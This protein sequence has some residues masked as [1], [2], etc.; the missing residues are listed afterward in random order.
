MRPLMNVRKKDQEE[1]E[2]VLAR[3]EKG[4]LEPPPNPWDIG[5]DDYLRS[6]KTAHVLQQWSEEMGEDRLLDTYGVTPGEMRARLDNA[7]WLL[8]STHE[9]A[10]LLGHK[11][12]LN[13][14][15]KSRLRL[16]YGVREELLSLVRLK[17]VGRARARALFRNNVKGL[18]ELRKIPLKRLSEIIGP[19][20][21]EQV[22]GQL[23]EMVAGD[24][25]Q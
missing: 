13:P 12:F 3:E 24:D 2:E 14:I 25:K 20:T 22:K 8:Y 10:L 4:M 16:R 11:A 1:L 18:A 7:D 21:A 15:R 17:G 5:Y 19:K 9:L 23:G 6:V